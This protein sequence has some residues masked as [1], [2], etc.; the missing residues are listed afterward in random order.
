MYM[1]TSTN[2]QQNSKQ[3]KPYRKPE[4]EIHKLEVQDVLTTSG[5]FVADM[6]KKNELQVDYSFW[7]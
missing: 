7:K 3:K 2:N 5:D 4:M 1:K 6:Y